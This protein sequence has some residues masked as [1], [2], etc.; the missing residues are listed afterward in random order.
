MN[1]IKNRHKHTEETD[2]GVEYIPQGAGGL[3]SSND[4]SFRLR[5]RD[6]GNRDPYKA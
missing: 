3:R 5:A 1:R 6:G 2:F 4:V